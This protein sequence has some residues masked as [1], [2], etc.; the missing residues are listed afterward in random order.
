MKDNSELKHFL[1]DDVCL[2]VI[3]VYLQKN[4]VDYI[5]AY[6]TSLGLSEPAIFEVEDVY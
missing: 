3:C 1:A 2:V 4:P 5:I 6:H